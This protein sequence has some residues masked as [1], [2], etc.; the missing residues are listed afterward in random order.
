MSDRWIYDFKI[1][2]RRLKKRYAAESDE[3]IWGLTF[4][5]RLSE[6]HKSNTLETTF[7]YLQSFFS[8]DFQILQE[9]LDKELQGAKDFVA[10]S[11]F[12]KQE[13]DEWLNKVLEKNEYSLKS[14]IKQNS[15]NYSLFD[16]KIDENYNLV[17]DIS[18]IKNT[19]VSLSEN[20]IEAYLTDEIHIICSYPKSIIS[21]K[22][23][24]LN[25]G[26]DF[27][28]NGTYFSPLKEHWIPCGTVFNHEKQ[29]ESKEPRALKRGGLSLLESG[30]INIKNTINNNLDN[31]KNH[32]KEEY[33]LDDLSIPELEGIDKPVEFIGGG[34]LIILNGKA[35]TGSELYNI[36]QFV[37]MPD[38]C[39]ESTNGFDS[40]Q[41]FGGV[42]RIMIARYNE[43]IFFLKAKGS[44]KNIQK[45]LLQKGFSDLICFDGSGGLFWANKDKII[46][47]VGNIS[48][49]GFA[50][51][52]AKYE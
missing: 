47:E 25:S 46:N 6:F 13:A 22:E 9:R 17:Y 48:P 52:V 4:L 40:L 19:I 41:L 28:T 37:S 24:Y 23:K 42:T 51:K 36:Q 10:V 8:S 7:L 35:V 3:Y 34:A 26:F 32:F 30:I 39:P 50:V 12:S 16:C 33:E 44:V 38:H 45:L 1:A 20:N 49:S 15:I 21:E 18:Y 27:V 11:G 31:I 2:F 14:F 5:A 43:K 29:F